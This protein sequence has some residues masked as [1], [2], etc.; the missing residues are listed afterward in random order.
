MSRILSRT[1]CGSS[2]TSRGLQR[3]QLPL[4]HHHLSLPACPALPL[5]LWTSPK[6]LSPS[7]PRCQSC[8]SAP[9]RPQASPACARPAHGPRSCA[10]QPC[11][12]T[13][14]CRGG[15]RCG[16][17]NCC[18]ALWGSMRRQEVGQHAL[19]QLRGERG[20]EGDGSC[21]EAAMKLPSSNLE[22]QH[23]IPASMPLLD[24]PTPAHTCRCGT[25]PA[26]A[27]SD[28]THRTWGTATWAV[29]LRIR[30]SKQHC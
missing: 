5:V 30:Y 25:R 27:A 23:L 19:M 17:A 6:A 28:G 22:Q 10:M 16:W 14:R 13:C 26:A 21:H 20:W 18:T 12:H 15:G 9:S 11:S 2:R 3:H 8:A 4:D 24:V 29:L 1:R 7:S